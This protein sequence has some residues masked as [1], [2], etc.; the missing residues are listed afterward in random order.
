MKKRKIALRNV[1]ILS[2]IVTSFIACDKDF[3]SIDSDIVNNENTT[4]YNTSREKFDVIA[5]NKKLDPVQTN[6]LPVNP[7]GVYNDPV[8][9]VT[10]ANF[11]SQMNAS[12]LDPDF[13]TFVS[14]DSVVLTIPYFNTSL[15]NNTEGVPEY[16]LDSIFGNGFI[17]FS[18]FESTYFLRDFDPSSDFDESQIYYSDASAS[19]SEPINNSFLE[20]ELIY[21][22]AGLNFR[23]SASAIRLDVDGEFSEY[24]EPALRVKLNKDYWQEKI[25]DK[26]GDPELSNQNNFNNYLRGLYFKAEPV[27]GS[28]SLSLLNLASTSANITIYYTKESTDEDN[29]DAEDVQSTISFTFGNT[30]SFLSTNYNVTLAD[31]DP[32]NGDE[33]LYLK[34]GEGSMAIINL[35]NGDDEGNSLELE[36]FRANNWLINEANLVFYVDQDMMINGD[37]PDRIYLYDLN[38]KTPLAD[39]YFDTS[40]SSTESLSRTSHLGPLQHVDDDQDEAGIKYRIRITEHINNILLNDSTNV[41][42][43]LVVSGNTNLEST[44][45]QYGI[46][47]DDE[48]VDK[49][50]GSAII[51]PKGTILFG[52]NTTNNDK[53]LQL[54]IF[55]TEEQNN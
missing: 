55:Y 49:I 22:T 41:K 11:V 53:K 51:S 46:Q 54:E 36:D 23:P 7:F 14:L 26:E 3:A 25:I 4:H 28:G 48:L 19:A 31:G 45:L 10:T 43:G 16:E 39:Y 5:Y 17:N 20:S 44:S 2:L 33:K 15:G 29:E 6:N 35:F 1:A 42:L 18:I 52:N 38:N 12:I 34:G 21:E 40:N 32:V 9:G 50:P 8:Y 30:A 13:G 47:G 24:I 37:E 27:S